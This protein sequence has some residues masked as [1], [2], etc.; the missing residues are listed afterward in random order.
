MYD[1]NRLG[2]VV[3]KGLVKFIKV[4]YQGL[5]YYTFFGLQTTLNNSFPKRIIY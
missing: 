5:Y 3:D 2:M 1:T 4:L